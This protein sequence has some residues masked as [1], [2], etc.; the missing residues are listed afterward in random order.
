M[1]LL[2]NVTNVFV[3]YNLATSNSKS[4]D[5]H[6]TVFTKF[7]QVEFSILIGIASFLNLLALIFIGHLIYF[8]IYLQR[9]GMTTYEYI[10]W[11]ANITRASKIKRRKSDKQADQ[12]QME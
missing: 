10:R 1:L 2:H 9:K 3:L 11:K 7:L 8:H 12:A 4:I 5:T 6:E